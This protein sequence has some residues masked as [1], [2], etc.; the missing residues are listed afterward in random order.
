MAT[1]AKEGNISYSQEQYNKKLGNVPI[2]GDYFTGKSSTDIANFAN[3]GF[4]AMEN[5]LQRTDKLINSGQLTEPQKL[6]LLAPIKNIPGFEGTDINAIA[7]DNKLWNDIIKNGSLTNKLTNLQSTFQKAAPS[8]TG[9]SKYA[10]PT[11]Q[12]NEMLAAAYKEAKPFLDTLFNTDFSDLEVLDKSIGG[13]GGQSLNEISK[14][15]EAFNTIDP[16]LYLNAKGTLIGSEGLSAPGQQAAQTTG[17]QTA[18]SA[19]G[20]VDP[21][22]GK[23]TPV[24]VGQPASEY[25]KDGKTSHPSPTFPGYKRVYAGKENLSANDSAVN[26]LFKQYHGRDANLQELNYWRNKKVGELEDTLAKTGIFSKEEA[27][28]IRSQMM[29]EGKTY[30]ANQAELEKLGGSAGITMPAGDN[31]MM[32]TPGATGT[33]SNAGNTGTGTGSGTGTGASGDPTDALIDQIA[34]AV[35]DPNA[36]EDEILSALE[37]I[38][39]GQIDPYYKQLIGQAQQDITTSINRGYE[40]RIRQLQTE[41]FNLAENISNT[42][43]SLAGKGMTFSGE[44]IKQLGTL[45]AFA[46]GTPAGM[47][48]AQLDQDG[49]PV[50]GGNV[51]PGQVLPAPA[52]SLP[53]MTPE[54]MG[55]EGSTNMNNRLIAESSRSAFNRSLEDIGTNAIRLLGTAGVIGLGLPSQSTAG[56]PNTTGTMQYDY[57]KTLQ[58]L[59]GNLSNQ[60]GDL[61]GYQGTFL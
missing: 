10:E 29:A 57:N 13:F 54:Q 8:Y 4:S 42:Q 23:E 60:E 28:K 33:G 46:Q 18:T 15:R 55:I 16:S 17:N 50:S 26:E 19:T 61:T 6:K 45:S 59:Y 1:S 11:A 58:S 2:T 5:W 56:Q 31:S 22:T 9:N 39:N 20:W 41:S 47:A 40:D 48:P 52:T 43:K 21:A 12:S 49:N 53:T 24:G 30:I 14:A 3:S 37:N 32:F 34:D 35:G 44:A 51:V 38:K 36:G 25:G 7:K 27:D